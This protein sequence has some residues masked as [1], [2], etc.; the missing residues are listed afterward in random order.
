MKNEDFALAIIDP[1]NSFMDEPYAELPVPGATADMKR[2]ARFILKNLKRLSKI[3][4]TLDSHRVVDIS[5]PTGW[6]NADGNPVDPKGMIPISHQDVVDGKYSW[7]LN[8]GWAL[9]YTKMLEAGGS[10]RFKHYLWPE[11]CIIGS[12]GHNV[13]QPLADAVHAWERE[14]GGIGGAEYL[15]KGSNPLTEHFG[16]FQAQVP[17]DNQP[18][19]QPNIAL[20][21]VLHKYKWVFAAGEARNICFSTSLEQILDLAP[22]LA[23]K[24]VILEDCMSDVPGIVTNVDEVFE[25]A[26]RAGVRFVKSTDNIDQLAPATV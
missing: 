23:P 10:S 24:L 17:I 16:V 3:L 13:Y 6:I 18:S 8:P 14:C 20:L 15:T 9:Q 26:R 25:R 12:K 22:D 2:L 7:T 11:H 4:V 19:T 5:H 21:K 1:Q